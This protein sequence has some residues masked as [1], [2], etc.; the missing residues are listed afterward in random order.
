MWPVAYLIARVT[1]RTTVKKSCP[2]MICAMLAALAPQ[3]LALI[4]SAGLG[5]KEH[6]V[7]RC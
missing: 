5:R 6:L 4:D 2:S 1:A 7:L 3:F